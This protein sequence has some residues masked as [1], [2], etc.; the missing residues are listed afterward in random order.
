MGVCAH[1]ISPMERAVDHAMLMRH[2]HQTG[3]GARVDAGKAHC[4]LRATGNKDGFARTRAAYVL[5][6]V[7]EDLDLVLD[8]FGLLDLGVADHAHLTVAL[9]AEE[10]AD[11]DVVVVLNHAR[12]GEVSIHE[13]HLVQVAAGHAG[14]HVV[15]VRADGVHGGLLL[16]AGVPDLGGDLLAILLDGE[17]ARAERANEGAAGAGD[18]H[19]TA[20]D[21]DLDR[22]RDRDRLGRES[23]LHGERGGMCVVMGK[24]K[25][26]AVGHRHR[27]THDG[28]SDDDRN[29]TAT[30]NK[31]R[32]KSKP[33]RQPRSLADPV[34]CLPA[35]SV[36]GV[37]RR[38][39]LF[40]DILGDTTRDATPRPIL[41]RLAK[42]A[43]Q[44]VE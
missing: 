18:G 15:D 22:L 26:V 35:A 38:A 34:A 40:G 28:D 2:R 6:A 14:H 8:V 27:T 19:H 39:R 3:K 9:L 23:E 21:V 4:T 33:S 31:T 29:T 13:A 10:V 37:C 7:A 43:P 17:G 44:V 41:A 32:N 12:D 30:K 20:V 36:L 1:T 16:G 42:A 25:D 11:G 24:K 5:D